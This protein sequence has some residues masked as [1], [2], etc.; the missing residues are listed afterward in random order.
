MSETIKQEIR[1]LQRI[2][3]HVEKLSPAAIVWL[4]SFLA[5]EFNADGTKP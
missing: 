2:V 4:R 3:N 5:D 1:R